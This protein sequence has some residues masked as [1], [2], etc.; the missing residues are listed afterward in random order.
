MRLVNH[1]LARVGRVLVLL[2]ELAHGGG[3]TRIVPQSQCCAVIHLMQGQR[4]Q[5]GGN[6]D[7]THRLFGVKKATHKVRHVR[8]Y[9]GICALE[10]KRAIIFGHTVAARHHQ[11]VI[12]RHLGLGQI[13][14][15]AQAGNAAGLF[16]NVAL[17]TCHRL[18]GDVVDHME[19]RRVG[20]D[21][22]KRRAMLIQRQQ[23]EHRLAHLRAIKVA[24]AG[25]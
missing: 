22:L 10:G 3:D 7:G 8:A 18:T 1:D 16:Q 17:R 11:R 23:G 24:A 21:A 25:E 12:V 19:L 15:L 6:T 5:C 13:Q 9:L 2:A 14:T 4:H 20:R